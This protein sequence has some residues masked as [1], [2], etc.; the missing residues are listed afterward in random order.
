[1]ADILALALEIRDKRFAERRLGKTTT[2]Q[3]IKYPNPI[4]GEIHK[5][6]IILTIKFGQALPGVV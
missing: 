4:S 3:Q 1:M 5:S 2:M 6:M